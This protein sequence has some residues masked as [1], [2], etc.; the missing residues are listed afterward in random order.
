MS[1]I[2][3]LRRLERLFDSLNRA[4][5]QRLMKLHE[6]RQEVSGRQDEL[7]EALSSSSPCMLGFMD[8]WLSESSRKAGELV[9]IDSELSEAVGEAATRKAQ[10]ERVRRQIFGGLVEKERKVEQSVIDEFSIRSG[11]D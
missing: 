10:L 7:I 5:R 2:E 11:K 3:R 6:Q 8:E 1:S 9:R 4:D